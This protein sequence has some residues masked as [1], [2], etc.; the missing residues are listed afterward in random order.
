[1]Y[2][3]G[4]VRLP[5]RVADVADVLSEVCLF[6]FG[7]ALCQ[8]I[9]LKLP[10]L[11]S[12]ALRL[13]TRVASSFPLP[14]LDITP[15]CFSSVRNTIFCIPFPYVKRKADDPLLHAVDA[16]LAKSNSI[17]LS[18]VLIVFTLPTKLSSESLNNDMPW[19]TIFIKLG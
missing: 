17:E 5:S 3:E 11:S 10:S 2:L 8:K 16:C 4:P 7:N 15:F 18:L 6:M 13:S 19:N 12:V 14:I 1:M 9:G